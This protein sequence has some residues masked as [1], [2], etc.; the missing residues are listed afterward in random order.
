MN[1]FDLSWC[2]FYLYDERH[3]IGLPLVGA[4][5]SMSGFI[6]L[7]IVGIILFPQAIGMYKL[8]KTD[9]FLI[10]GILG[11]VIAFF[12]FRN[13]NSEIRMR[14]LSEYQKYKKK[15][16]RKTRIRFFMFILIPI[17]LLIVDFTI[18]YTR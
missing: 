4:T 12:I 3:N 14:R 15:N 18:A 1:I 9:A 2:M 7:L 5:I 16:P 13:R 11:L 8:P 17:L 6:I 10:Y